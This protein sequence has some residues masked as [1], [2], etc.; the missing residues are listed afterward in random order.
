[1]SELTWRSLQKMLPDMD[2]K[3]VLL[4]L[5]KECKAEFPRLTIVWRLHQ[6]YTMLRSNREREEL[7]KAIK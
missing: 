7:M 1:M 3:T 4:F 2:E 5:E 6:R